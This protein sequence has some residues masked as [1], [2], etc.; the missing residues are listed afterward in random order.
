M[1]CDPKGNRTPIDRLKTC[2]PE[3]LDDGTFI[4]F[5]SKP[6]ISKNEQ[7]ASFMIIF[8]IETSCDDTCISFIQANENKKSKIKV[9][10]NLVS[11]QVELH[12][13]YGG[14]YPFLAQREHKK[15]LPLLFEKAKKE[16]GD[17]KI[18]LIAL[19]IGPG[20]DPCLWAGLDFAKSLSNKLKVPIL[21]VNHL[22]GHIYA[23]F[24]ESNIDFNK[25]FPAICLIVSGGHTQLI[26]VKSFGNYEILG[27][28]RDDAAGECFD[29]IGR[30]LGLGFPGGP[31]IEKEAEKEIKKETDIEF[32][33]PMIN[34]DNYDFSFSGLKTAVLYFHRK[35]PSKVKK[36]FN[37]TREVCREVQ[38]SIIDVLL[39]KTVK[40]AKNYNIKS[41]ILG[42]GV[43]ANKEL[44]KRFKKKIKNDFPN[45]NLY[46]PQLKNSTDNSL[47]TGLVAYYHYLNRDKGYLKEDF[48]VNPNLRL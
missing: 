28:T 14:I 2:R 9:L 4:Y 1:L 27:E 26:L 33:R 24:V 43:T 29:K 18:D 39:S 21:P 38:N 30:M 48:K 46:L 45:L 41:I 31:A 25:V 40:A 13:E 36:D 32:P 11:S 15:N 16:A 20:L 37:Y 7:K 12:K 10:A 22:E 47:M 44:R 17:P 3:P 6:I 23:S 5:L 19:T 42:G 34:Q 35:Q 8:S